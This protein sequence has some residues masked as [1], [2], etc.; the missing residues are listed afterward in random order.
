MRRLFI[1]LSFVLGCL[2]AY[3]QTSTDLEALKNAKWE[4]TVTPEGLVHKRAAIAD[5]YGGPQHINLVEVPSGAK[6]HYGIAVSEMKKAS[7]ISKENQAL[8]SINGSYYNMEVGNSVC[9]L[10]VGKEV[11]DTTGTNELN[12]SGPCA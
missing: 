9:F 11:L 4:T 5:L 12:M 6:V 2:S 7:L 3:A 10:K 1:C 8:A